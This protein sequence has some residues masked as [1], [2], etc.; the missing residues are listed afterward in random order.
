MVKKILVLLLGLAAFTAQ[1]MHAAR[2]QNQPNTTQPNGARVV[3][4]PDGKKQV[5]HLAK[6]LKMTSDQSK[7]VRAILAD[8]DH[9]LGIVQG[10][11]LLSNDAKNGRIATILSGSND[12][13]AGVL[14]DRQNQKFDA[15]L[16]R[17][18]RHGRKNREQAGNER[19]HLPPVV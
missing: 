2:K 6:Q 16:A 3:R 18:Q 7:Y 17:W 12:Q 19:L 14:N 5:A 10:S 9:Q 15:M 1:P 4:V 11:D 8:R 13:I